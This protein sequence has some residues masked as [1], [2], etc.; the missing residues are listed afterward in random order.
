MLW[1]IEVWEDN[2]QKLEFIQLVSVTKNNFVIK[3]S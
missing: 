1:D 2:I 3:I